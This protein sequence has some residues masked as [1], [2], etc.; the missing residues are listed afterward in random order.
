MAFSVFS[1]FVSLFTLSIYGCAKFKHAN[2][3]RIAYLRSLK[4]RLKEGCENS[5]AAERDWKNR[6]RRV[7]SNLTIEQLA[8]L[9]RGFFRNRKHNCNFL[10]KKLRQKE[11]EQL[12]ELLESKTCALQEKLK[13]SMHEILF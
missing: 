12:K 10:D 9:K 3:G 7:R 13:H 11:K 5:D 4:I 2:I 1:I 6:L 8:N